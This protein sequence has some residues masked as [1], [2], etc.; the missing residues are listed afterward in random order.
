MVSGKYG[1]R[2]PVSTHVVKRPVLTQYT[3]M[4]SMS[5]SVLESTAVRHGHPTAGGG[6]TA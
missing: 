5:L 3:I 2:T 4:M 6:R 1:L